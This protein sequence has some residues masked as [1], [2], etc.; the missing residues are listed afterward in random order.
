VPASSVCLLVSGR[1]SAQMEV[2]NQ[3]LR[4]F[5]ILVLSRLD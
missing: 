1:L 2:D 3:L 5:A 4:N